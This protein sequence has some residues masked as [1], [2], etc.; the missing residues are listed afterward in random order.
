M[1]TNQTNRQ[2]LLLLFENKRI[3][4]KQGWL[5]NTTPGRLSDNFDFG[6]VEGM[7]LGLA[8]GDSPGNTS[9]G[10][11]PRQRHEVYGEIRGYLPDRKVKSGAGKVVRG[12]PSDDTQLAF[13]TLEQML[14]DNGLNPDHLAGRFCRERIFG[15]G[16]TVREF[17]GNYRSGRIPWY[18]CGPRSAGN[19]ALMR[20]VPIVFLY[21]KAPT[22]FSSIV[23]LIN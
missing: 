1:D 15:I 5:F 14:Q 16:S 20:I 3:N 17:T 7:M 12:Y 8:I 23:F 4:I 6:R 19:G 18:E 9:E 21:L 10:M 11:L 22:W 2:K 13:W